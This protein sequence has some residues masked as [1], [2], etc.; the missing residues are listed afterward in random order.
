MDTFLSCVA[1]RQA[2]GR[3]AAFPGAA[4]AALPFMFLR[5]GDGP[6]QSRANVHSPCQTIPGCKGVSHDDFRP[7]PA[8]RNRVW[9][10]AWQVTFGLAGGS[11]RSFSSPGNAAAR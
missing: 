1:A 7:S 8:S 3:R 5:V 10:Q 2:G 4:S 6:W 9:C 11:A